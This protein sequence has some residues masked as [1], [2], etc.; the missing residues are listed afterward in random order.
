MQKS[1]SLIGLNVVDRSCI[2]LCVSFK[3]EWFFTGI[4]NLVKKVS[5][6][7]LIGISYSTKGLK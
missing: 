2:V 7:L 4:L 5:H 1:P 3:V 6:V